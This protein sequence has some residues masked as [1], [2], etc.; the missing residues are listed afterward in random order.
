MTTIE[1][2]FFII[3]VMTITI[4]YRKLLKRNNIPPKHIRDKI[5]AIEEELGELE[6][7]QALAPSKQRERRI[8]TLYR[9]L[10]RLQS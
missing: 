9:N 7:I 5:E 10:K 6:E 2:A 4:V 8:E 3:C 1:A